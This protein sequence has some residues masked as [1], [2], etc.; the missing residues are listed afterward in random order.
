L[1]AVAAAALHWK[2]LV[3]FIAMLAYMALSVLALQKMEMWTVADL[4]TTVLWTLTAG[5]TM[6]FD[7]S[8]VSKSPRYF[9][10]AVVD[11][12]KI[13]VVLEFIANFYQLNLLVELILVPIATILACMLVVA[14][15]KAEFKQVSS[16]LKNIFALLGLTLLAY[17]IRRI[18]MDMGSFVQFSTLV[19]FMLPIVHTVLFLPFIFILAVLVSYENIWVRL[20]FVIKDSELRRFIKLRLLT[21][22]GINFRAVDDSMSRILHDRPITREEVIASIRRSDPEN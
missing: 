19:D 18:Y 6:I 20:N 14:E 5:V 11:G 4:K 1:V 22:F 12:L 17:A 15:T 13:G 7:V 3:A 10:K 2:I 8:S 9:R 16:L 21:R